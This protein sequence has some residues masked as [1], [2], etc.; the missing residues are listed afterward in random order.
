MRILKPETARERKNNIFN[1][2]VSHYII[3][4]KPVSSDTICREGKFNLSSATIRNILKE[5]EEEG[6]LNQV[7]TSGG[8]IPSDKGYRAYV[9][10]IMKAQDR[11]E[12]EK[13]LL[14]MEYDRKMERLDAFLRHTTRMLADLSRKTGFTFFEDIINENLKR[15]DIVKVSPK[16]FLFIIVTDSGLIRHEAFISEK[17]LEKQFLR[18]FVFKFNKRFKNF[19]ISEIENVLLKEF[20][21][22]EN[23]IH[24]SNLLASVLRNIA[25]EEES[26]YLEGIG[27]IYENADETDIDEIR[28]IARL[29]EEKEK[30]YSIL[31]EKLKEYSQKEKVLGPVSDNK[32]GKR[33]LDVSIGSENSIKEFKNFSLVSSTYCVKDRPVGLVGIIGYKRM[34][35]PKVISIVDNVSSMIEEIFKEW[36]SFMNDE[37]F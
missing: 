4:G 1:W 35:Y 3:T 37:E 26:I 5:L 32:T 31:R 2:V 12:S 9:D 17:D 21:S 11:A 15:I 22:S 24:L 20:R 14:E 10:Y 29:L 28:S 13:E 30:I 8:R 23:E 19:K 36:E 7:H 27:R 6:Y 33:Y 34:E 25:K 16:N 18:S